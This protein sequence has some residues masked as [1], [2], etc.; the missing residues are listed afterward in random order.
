MFSP[1]DGL[2]ECMVNKLLSTAKASPNGIVNVKPIFQASKML[3]YLLTSP[4][5]RWAFCKKKC[6]MIFLIIIFSNK[7]T[8][9]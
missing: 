4:S 8:F 9:S 7:N 2:A 1:M 3:P 6:Y 5:L